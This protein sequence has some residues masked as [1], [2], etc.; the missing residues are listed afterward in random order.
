MGSG[1]ADVGASLSL[2][3]GADCGSTLTLPAQA[4]AWVE[5]NSPTNNKGTDS[6]LKVKSQGGSDNFRTLVRFTLPATL[7]TGCVVQSATLRLYIPSG[8]PGRTL[9]ALRLT[10]NWSEMGVTWGNQPGTTGAA[11]TTPSG[12]GYREWSVTAQV[13]AMLDAAAPHGFLIRDASEGGSGAEQ[14]FHSREHNENP[15]QLV[16]QFGPG[17]PPGTTPPNTTIMTGPAAATS[18]S[19]ATFTFSTQTTGATFSC[20]LDGAAFTACPSPYTISP[21]AV[22]QHTFAVRATDTAGNPDPSPA[23]FTWTVT[24][25]LPPLTA[26]CGQVVVTSGLL[27]NDVTNCPGDGLVIGAHG[28]TLDLNGHTV[29]G[30]GLGV[31]IRNDGFDGVIISYGT[32]QEFDVGVQLNSG[33]AFNTLTALTLRLNQVVGIELLDADDGSNGN[34]LIANAVTGN[35]G[36]IR[37]G[38]GTTG[39][40]I[41]QNALTDNA[42]FALSLLSSD[43]NTIEGN[44]ISGSSDTAVLFETASYNVVRGNN[45]SESA[46]GALTLQADSNFNRVEINNI[47]EAT[48]PERRALAPFEILIKLCPIMAHPPIPEKKPVTTLANP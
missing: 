23:T 10:G 26:S 6:I 37:L 7:P 35:S 8:T 47:S 29:D 40:T 28:I 27:L 31:G 20:S 14:Q 44:L 19:N 12:S 39:T 13:Q 46:D 17:I 9:Q 41:A 33:T 34:S 2:A 45:I 4:D 30:I 18:S 24:P 16:I 42:N 1:L 3:A 38:N 22:G 21:V 11:A 15:P 48:I 25:P 32:V 43:H 36:G 5:Q